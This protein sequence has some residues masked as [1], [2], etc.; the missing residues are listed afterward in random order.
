MLKCTQLAETCWPHGI[1]A[2][3]L[4]GTAARPCPSSSPA[5]SRLCAAWAPANLCIFA[6]DLKR[7]PAGR[8][9]ALS[10]FAA[11]VLCQL[12]ARL[13][14]KRAAGLSK[15][16]AAVLSASCSP[17]W[18]QAFGVKRRQRWAA[19]QL[20]QG[21]VCSRLPPATFRGVSGAAPLALNSATCRSPLAWCEGPAVSPVCSAVSVWK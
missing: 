15:G 21:A 13:T 14:R 6:G 5:W 10:C 8:T 12:K 2:F 1:P 19:A 4:H 3:V 20:R 18:G 11:R 7:S 17:G 9:L 16:R